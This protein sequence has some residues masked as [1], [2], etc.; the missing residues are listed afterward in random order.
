MNEIEIA[1]KKAC[2]NEANKKYY[3]K[4]KEKIKELVKCELC[5]GEYQRC[6]VRTHEKSKRHIL[7]KEI[8]ELKDQLSQK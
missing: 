3:E 6:S 1:K 2:H 8:K 4:N 7:S 5:G